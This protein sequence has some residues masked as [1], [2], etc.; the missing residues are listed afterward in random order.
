MILFDIITKKISAKIF[1]EHSETLTVRHT[2]ILNLVHVSLIIVVVILFI[3]QF[4]ESGKELR[5]MFVS[6][7]VAA[8]VLGL[9]AQSSLGNV[10]CGFTILSSHPFEIGDR[11]QIGTDTQAGYVKRLTLQTTTL[12]TYTGEEITIPNSVVANNRIINYSHIT[13]FAYPLEITVA[14]GTDIKKAKAII[15]DVLSSHAEWF[16]DDPI[17]LVKEAGDYGI[18]LRTLVTT[19]LP[20]DN[21]QVCSDCLEG[22]IKRFDEAG[23]EIPYPTNVVIRAKDTR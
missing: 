22:I 21:P 15:S 6:G 5:N 18:K 17:V 1:K 10:F 16:G 13:G 8:I 11:V 7:G 19:V 3:L 23:I 2:F 14:Y 20:D 9:A 4:T 12:H